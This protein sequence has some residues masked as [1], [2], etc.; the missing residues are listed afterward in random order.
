MTAERPLVS[1]IPAS[2]AAEIV[3]NGRAGREWVVIDVRGASRWAR[4]RLKGVADDDYRGG[5]IKGAV[6]VASLSFEDQLPSLVQR[7][8][9]GPCALLRA[10]VTRQCPTSSSTAR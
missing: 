5:H 10:T 1:Y 2:D 3:K 9:D 6:N 4:R 7:F 8:A